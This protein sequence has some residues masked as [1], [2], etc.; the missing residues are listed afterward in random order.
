MTIIEAISKGSEV[1]ELYHRK[2]SHN[3]FDAKKADNDLKACPSCRLVWEITVSN[4]TIEHKYYRNFPTFGKEK[5]VCPGCKIRI[6][7]KYYNNAEVLDP[8]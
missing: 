5:S 2:D 8:E 3:N 6:K 7:N 4:N 1:K